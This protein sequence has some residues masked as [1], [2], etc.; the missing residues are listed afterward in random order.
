MSIVT[1]ASYAS[2]K[3]GQ[4]CGFDVSALV[5]Y[6]HG[7]LG[8][9]GEIRDVRK[10]SSGQSN[11]TY[12][13][14]TSAGR[15]VLRRKPS[16]KLLPSAHAVDRE[17]A[18]MKALRSS[19]TV[20]VPEPLVLCEDDAV[21]GSAFYVMTY[22]DG[23]IFADPALP[24]LDRPDREA[25]YAD[26]VRTLAAL[27]EVD[28]DAAGL[29]AFGKA[30]HYYER[31]LGRW[32]KQYRATET[33]TIA[34]VERLMDWLAVNLPAEEARPALIHGDFRLENMV[35]E[36][37]GPRL[38]AVLDWELS[39]LGDPLA[40][41]GHLCMSVGLPDL[42]PFRGVDAKDRERLGVPTNEAMVAR[43]CALRGIDYPADWAFHIA[44]AYFRYA[45]ITQGVYRRSLEGNASN[46]TAAEAGR[47]VRPLAE[48]GLAEAAAAR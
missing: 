3:A 14:A 36:R 15:F 35:Y 17:F 5:A 8:F 40:D 28:V 42:P 23:R 29:A 1:T 47:A 22:E 38:K 44:F 43:Y 7:T 26:L 32:R 41:L 20:P 9:V 12:L 34:E 33:E 21:I 18:V 27:H 46:E 48:L 31:Q 37:A 45:A 10:F 19:G 39:T 25:V 30:G 4:A 2:D 13:L 11:P 24:E 16:G 6:L